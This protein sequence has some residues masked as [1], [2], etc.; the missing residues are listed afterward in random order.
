MN[1]RARIW[2]I[3]FDQQCMSNMIRLHQ[4][5]LFCVLGQL[6]W[7][8]YTAQYSL[9]FKGKA[10]VDYFQRTATSYKHCE[11]DENFAQS[12][13]LTNIH[14]HYFYRYVLTPDT[15]HLLPFTRA[16]ICDFKS[17]VVTHFCRSFKC[18][19]DDLIRCFVLLRLI[20]EIAPNM[21]R[22]FAARVVNLGYPGC[23]YW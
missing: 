12:F 6:N 2:T 13:M 10:N 17:W 21:D 5:K 8:W 11:H 4:I 19:C 16:S 23:R 1:K 14:S 3:K 22:A 18:A 7:E 20:T 15:W 9:Y